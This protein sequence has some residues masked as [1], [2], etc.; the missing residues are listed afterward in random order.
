ML[1]DGSRMLHMNERERKGM[2]S[3]L[4]QNII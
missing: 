1:T 2:A 4:V 3:N